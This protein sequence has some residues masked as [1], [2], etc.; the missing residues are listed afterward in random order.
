MHVHFL[1]LHVCTV[2]LRTHV[3]IHSFT[4]EL[5][6]VRRSIDLNCDIPPGHASQDVTWYRESAELDTNNIEK[7]GLAASHM[8]LTV[9]NV[10]HTD[11]G[12]YS[13]KYSNQVV[14]YNAECLIVYGEL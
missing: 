14:H 2:H 10:E 8:R 6:G 4:E 9:K 1:S 12:N 11:E 13:C 5:G 7:Y 3:L